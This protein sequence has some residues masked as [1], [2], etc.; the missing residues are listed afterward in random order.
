MNKE[1]RL[2]ILQEEIYP[3]MQAEVVESLVLVDQELPHDQWVFMSALLMMLTSLQMKEEAKIGATFVLR[4]FV[5]V[6]GLDWDAFKKA[7]TA[8]I[9][10][11]D[12]R[13]SADIEDTETKEETP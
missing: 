3:K 10:A 12:P 1:E 7:A 8:T 11:S 9:R 2:K 4:Q 13:L 5:E 6:N